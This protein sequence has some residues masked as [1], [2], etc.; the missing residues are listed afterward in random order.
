MPVGLESGRSDPRIDRH[1]PHGEVIHPAPAVASSHTYF[2][3]MLQC[4][5]S[6]ATIR[7]NPIRVIPKG[8]TP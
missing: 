2:H 6:F 5:N 8:R 7:E 3:L 4:D 1:T